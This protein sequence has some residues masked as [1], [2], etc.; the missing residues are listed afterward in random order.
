MA[1]HLE[2]T[3]LITP[4]TPSVEAVLSRVGRTPIIPLERLARGLPPSV[5][6]LAKAEWHN[7][8][9]S[10]KDRPAA[11]ILR[12]ALVHGL[13]TP[14]K[15]LLDSTSGNMGIAYA[16]L[17]ARL[18]VRV[19]LTLPANVTAERKAILHALGAELTFTDPVEGT[20]GA[21]QAAQELSSR[22]PDRYYYAD[23]YSNPANVQAHYE[24]TGP[25]LVEQTGGGLT[26][27]VAGLG[28][29]G[30]LM[31]AGRYLR[32]HL[33]NARLIAV[34]PDGPLHGLEG[35]KHLASAPHPALFDPA[36][37]D[38]TVEVGTEEAHAM[39]IR[40][41]REEGLLVGVSAAA[42]AVASL[43][44][45]ERVQAGLIVAVFPD[46]GLKYLSMPF[47]STV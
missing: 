14:D 46:S 4:L 16:T 6:L 2:T 35:L 8:S 3:G 21:R 44:V 20:E 12:A 43:R 28:T 19:H 13:L 10:V 7:P 24:T 34:Q 26:H 37:A 41:A 11:A 40:L 25:E 1:T 31:G 27:F 29:T 5:R 47:W 32:E 17:G 30:T 33:P 36:F 45:A 15:I 9:G 23:Q 22:T 39:A 38:E 18:A 42:A